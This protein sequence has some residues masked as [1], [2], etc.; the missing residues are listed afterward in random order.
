MKEQFYVVAKHPG[1]DAE[2][3]AHSLT[4]ETMQNFVGGLIEF[5]FP[6]GLP[7]GVSV[8]MNEEGKLEGLEPC[9]PIGDY[10]VAVG[11]ALFVGSDGEGGTIGLTVAQAT[12]VMEWLGERGL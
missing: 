9:F 2:I 11:P 12:A 10:D 8:V 4:L 1:Q 7:E 6:P 5:I 3:I